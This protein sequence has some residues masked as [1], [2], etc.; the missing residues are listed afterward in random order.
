MQVLGTCFNI[1]AYDKAVRT[2]LLDSSVKL[3]E[4]LLKPS[5]QGILNNAAV[6]VEKAA[7]EEV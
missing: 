2:T 5:Q 6:K 4:Q 7:I 1:N 3:N